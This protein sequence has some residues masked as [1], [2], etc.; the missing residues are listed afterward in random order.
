MKLREVK[1]KQIQEEI[2]KEIAKI[3]NQAEREEVEENFSMEEEGQ[4]LKQVIVGQQIDL[5]NYKWRVTVLE[6]E[7]LGM[8]LDCRELQNGLERT[9]AQLNFAEGETQR[10]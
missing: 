5:D 8:V 6:A 9:K 10:L 1:F 3:A 4:G 7:K 2:D